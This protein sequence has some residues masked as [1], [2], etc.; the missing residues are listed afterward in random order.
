MIGR[1]IIVLRRTVCDGTDFG[2]ASTTL[3]RTTN[4]EKVLRVNQGTKRK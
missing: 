4:N 3:H 2:D 1:V